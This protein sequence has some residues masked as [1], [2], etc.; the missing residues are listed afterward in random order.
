MRFLESTRD[1][2]EGFWAEIRCAGRPVVPSERMRRRVWSLP[3]AP[4][5]LDKCH[6]HVLA[7]R[8]DHEFMLSNVL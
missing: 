8:A 2:S 6:R 5:W 3:L 7:G 1:D 4:T